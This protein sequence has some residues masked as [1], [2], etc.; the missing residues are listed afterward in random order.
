[1]R[2]GVCDDE[3]EV[4]EYIKEKVNR[5]FPKAEV[6]LFESG[7]DVLNDRTLPDILFL[8]IQMP[9]MNGMETAKKLRKK[10]KKTVIIFVT[11]VEEYVFQA[12]DVDAFHYLVKPFTNEKFYE[13]L[14]KAVKRH[15]G[16]NV[17]CESKEVNPPLLITA[18][19]KH[20]V[21]N[22]NDIVY[23]EVYDRKVMLHT[24]HSDIE[25]YGKMK[26]LEKKAGEDF[27]RPHRA[28]L[29]NL[30]YVKKYDSTTI[31]L[32]KGQALMAKQNYQEF[33]K[34]FLRFNRRIGK[35][36]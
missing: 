19:G 31:W 34:A 6:V 3:K 16:E 24:L 32:E 29:V 9:G 28:Y 13:V 30:H 12:F 10:D 33:V 5:L 1:M 36:T 27:F 20:V 22:I 8:D 17:A 11:A 15:Q 18:Q 2:I 25:Y 7:Q 4:R 21:V 23:A 14:Q 35:L 26:E